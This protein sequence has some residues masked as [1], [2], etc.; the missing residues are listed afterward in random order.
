M[1]NNLEFPMKINTDAIFLSDAHENT[2]KT[3][4]LEF[5]EALDDG[6]ISMPSQLFLLGKSSL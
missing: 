3:H 2:N 1:K 6:R 5:L 4:F